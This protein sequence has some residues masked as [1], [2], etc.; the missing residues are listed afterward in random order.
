MKTM[1]ECDFYFAIARETISQL[2]FTKE[3]FQATYS[4]DR[5]SN[6]C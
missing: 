4:K 5:L 6:Q 2:H 1:G 3:P